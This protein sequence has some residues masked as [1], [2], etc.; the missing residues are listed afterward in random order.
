MQFDIRV[1]IDLPSASTCSTTLHLPL[2]LSNP[3][4]IKSRMDFAYVIAMALVTFSYLLT[5][6]RTNF[7]LPSIS[8]HIKKQFI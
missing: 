4:L 8:I 5:L 6:L 7:T 1:D 2:Q 3:D